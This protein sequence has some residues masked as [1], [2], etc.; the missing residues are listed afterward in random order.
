MNHFWHLFVFMRFYFVVLS[1]SF[2]PRSMHE[3]RAI[4]SAWVIY[5]NKLEE[6][7]SQ[8]L[9]DRFSPNIHRMI[10]V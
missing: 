7:W 4:C 5:K 8:D 3:E 1:S 9:L 2:I 10:D 6:K